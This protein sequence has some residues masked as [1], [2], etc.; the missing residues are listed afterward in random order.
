M[1]F[2]TSTDTHF[3]KSAHIQDESGALWPVARE[4][5]GGKVGETGAA[6]AAR[7]VVTLGLIT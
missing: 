6:V 1:T 4:G 5:R 7:E 2:H 3:L